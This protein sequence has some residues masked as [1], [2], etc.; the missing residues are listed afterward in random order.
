MKKVVSDVIVKGWQPETEET[1]KRWLLA[2][3]PD[4]TPKVDDF[5][6]VEDV[7]PAPAPGQL[8]VRNLYLSVDPFQRLVMNAT[9]RNVE[10]VP[11]YG[12]MLGDVVGEVV[13][14]HH[15]DFKDG[16]VV[17]GVLGWQNYA[18]TRGGGHYIHNRSGLRVVDETLGP[19]N[20][21]ASVLGRPGMT[22]YFSMIL[23]CKPKPG[24]VM[25]VTTAAGAVGH[26][27]GQI[28]KIH[29]ATVIGITSSEEKIR[30]ITEEM[31]FDAGINYKEVNDI[32]AAVK[33]ECP[34]GVDIYYD[35]VGGPMAEAIL[36]QLNPGGRVSY[37]GS[38]EQYNTFEEDGSPWTWK[39]DKP[40]FIIHDYVERYDEGRKAMSEWIKD[41]KLK[42]RDD[43]V[44][45]LENAADAFIGL[46]QGTNVGK[47]LV[48]V[49]E[50]RLTGEL[51]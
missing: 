28:G 7:V 50:I 9:P 43:I 25:V 42:Y 19:L 10:V 5:M 24:D 8:L 11:L 20:T 30:F 15:P 17:N 31:G 48:R 12:V 6:M 26:L 4:G 33:R 16:D 41:G 51:A 49:N 21:A 22:A 18:L 47:R 39:M 34:K 27:A 2:K 44:D 14:S 32:A 40:M 1:H 45:G 46:F 35:N 3:H 23:E 36:S 38:T 13:K 37:V 29:G